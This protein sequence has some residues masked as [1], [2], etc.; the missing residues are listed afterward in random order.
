MIPVPLCRLAVQTAL[1]FHRARLFEHHEAPLVLRVEGDPE[2]LFATILGGG[3]E[4]GLGIHRGAGAFRS[5][6]DLSAGSPPQDPA[7][8]ACELWSI[9]VDRP[10]AVPP[11]LRTIAAR[12]GCSERLVPLFL[13]VPR[14]RSSRE[15]HA[16]EL[17]TMLAAMAGILQAHARSLL[18]PLPLPGR[19][20]A[21]LLEL[22]ITGGHRD[23]HV[24]AGYATFGDAEGAAPTIGMPPHADDFG[25]LDAKWVA[26]RRSIRSAAGGEPGAE[27]AVLVADVDGGQVVMLRTLP[28]SEMELAAHAL[29]ELF[30]GRA[31]SGEGLPAQLTID[32]PELYAAMREGLAAAGVRCTAASAPLLDRIAADPAA[33]QGRP[34][35][36]QDAEPPDRPWQRLQDLLDRARDHRDWKAATRPPQER[37]FGRAGEPPDPDA[38]D[39]FETWYLLHFRGK[40]GRRTVA[41]RLLAGSLPEGERALLEQLLATSPTIWRVDRLDGDTAVLADSLAGGRVEFADP[42]LADEVDTG[43]LL[44]GMVLP[45][46]EGPLLVELGPR[47]PAL[48][49]DEVLAALESAGLQLTAAGLAAAPHLIGRLWT[50]TYD[51]L[52]VQPW[53]PLPVLHNTDG[54]P[55]RPQALTFAVADPAALAAALADRDDLETSGEA[56]WIWFRPRG[57]QRTLLARLRLEGGRLEVQVDSAARGERARSWLEALPGVSFLHR[58]ED[59]PAAAIDTPAPDSAPDPAI[60]MPFLRQH[61][62]A[63]LDKALPALGGRTP[64]Q[65]AVTERGREQVRSLIESLSEPL[66]SN[67]AEVAAGMEALRRDMLR[68][69]ALD[70]D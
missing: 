36:G 56:R 35:A 26:G 62:I 41:E 53:K 6:Q 65:A 70:R 17:R 38:L 7:T 2:P 55:L 60:L 28:G 24:T 43:T 58:S 19:G 18:R 45:Q 4:C 32:D 47:I 34:R 15:P 13:V 59:P 37:F 25:Q 51:P 52:E 21:R 61:Y 23:P 40:Q 1:E 31:G 64:R 11:E 33:F 49:A 50:W 67:S 5:L 44:F 42:D 63:W 22:L 12:A 46:P 10:G 68:E 57:E 54:E 9:T 69:L 30:G 8:R 39:A 48:E 14:G 29:I 16:R 20:P 27:P 3:R 66:N